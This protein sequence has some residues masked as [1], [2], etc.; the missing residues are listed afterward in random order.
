VGVGTIEAFSSAFFRR[1]PEKQFR[2]RLCDSGQAP[3]RVEAQVLNDLTPPFV[4]SHFAAHSESH[5]TF[6]LHRFRASPRDMKAPWKI[7]GAI[8]IIA[9]DDIVIERRLSTTEVD[10][11]SM[12]R[13][14]QRLARPSNNYKRPRKARPRLKY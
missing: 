14:P 5:Y 4:L 10:C 12:R 6:P 2:A 8:F 13:A 9:A 1:L 7:P 11:V 3:Y